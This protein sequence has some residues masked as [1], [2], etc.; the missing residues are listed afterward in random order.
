M[1]DIWSKMYIGLHV[2]RPLFLFDFNETFS[3]DFRKKIKYHMSWKPV[4][5]EP[6]CF[7]WTDGQTGGRKDR[8][9]EANSRFLQI[10]EKRLKDKIFSNEVITRSDAENKTTCLSMFTLCHLQVCPT[11]IS[12]RP[13][14]LHL[15]MEDWDLILL[16]DF[17]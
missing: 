16:Q 10:C 3:T 9:D 6:S 1:S 5:W 15:Y 8:H 13:F 12:K 2:K 14:I 11:R 7:L 4:Q 17:W